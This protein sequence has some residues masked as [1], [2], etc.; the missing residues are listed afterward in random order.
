[1]KRVISIILT[2]VLCLSLMPVITAHAASYNHID[3]SAAAKNTRV[4][5]RKSTGDCA[6]ASIA[7]VEAFV[8]NI[9]GNSKAVYDAVKK[10]NNN[11]DYIY[12]N[13][14]GYMNYGLS[15]DHG[16]NK[17]RFLQVVYNELANG[18]PAIVK[19]KVNG[20]AH[21]SLAVAYSGST[22]K[23]EESGFT[24]MDVF[25]S[26]GYMHTNMTTWARGGVVNEYALRKAGI[27]AISAMANSAQSQSVN[28]QE[29]AITSINKNMK[30]N[31][32]AGWT[33]RF[34]DNPSSGNT[35]IGSI[36]HNAT[37]FVYG[38]TL[39]K[40]PNSTGTL[41]TYAKILWNNR[42]GWVS[43]AWLK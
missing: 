17:D 34:C 36:P 7:S 20:R 32:G 42:V 25:G 1:M 11:S 5:M 6:I 10:A 38:A 16:G 33:L 39:S 28:N 9:T 29:P 2:V 4:A 40:Y 41:I 23:L 31:V 27:P 43:M 30:V 19:R 13:K 22:S 24:V 15:M 35:K 26:S 12:W 18:R 3:L 14:V 37:V 8:N 21:Y